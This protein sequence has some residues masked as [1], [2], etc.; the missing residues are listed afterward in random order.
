MPR[1]LRVSSA[2][3]PATAATS[4]QPGLRS[5]TPVRT[6]VRRKPSLTAL[7]LVGRYDPSRTRRRPRFGLCLPWPAFARVGIL[8]RRLVIAATPFAVVSADLFSGWRRSCQDATHL[9][10]RRLVAFGAREFQ[11]SIS[12]WAASY[13]K[14]WGAPASPPDFVFRQRKTARAIGCVER[15]FTP[16]QWWF[17]S[18]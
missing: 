9:R 11:A 5:G 3:G 12:G 18:Y 16:V 15:R 1:S 7:S 17:Y 6:S 2:S 14:A 4:R 8:P 13:R 10:V